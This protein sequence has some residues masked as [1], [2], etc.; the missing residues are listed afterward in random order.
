MLISS[1]ISWDMESYTVELIAETAISLSSGTCC[2]LGMVSFAKFLFFHV[3][4]VMQIL[5]LLQG[6][7]DAVEWAKSEV[8]VP[9]ETDL[10]D[11][12]AYPVR[13]FP[14][15]HIDLTLLEADDDATSLSSIDQ[16]HH[17]S[18]E[19]YLRGR[20]SGSSIFD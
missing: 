11:E 17:H 16:N 13:S 15:H 18:L 12:E 1:H 8:N 14:S 10:Q 20:L 3:F 4:L 6:V 7:E 9:K 5:K 2:L 19:D